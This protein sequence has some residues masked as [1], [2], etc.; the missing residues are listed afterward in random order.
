MNLHTDYVRF[1]V[2]KIRTMCGINVPECS[3]LGIRNPIMEVLE[4]FRI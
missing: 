1:G 2:R 4:L 3:P